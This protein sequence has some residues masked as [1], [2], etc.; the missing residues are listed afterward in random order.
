M[1]ELVNSPVFPFKLEGFQSLGHRDKMRVVGWQS[2][3]RGLVTTYYA[4]VEGASVN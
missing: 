1:N 2:A 3:I 4:Y